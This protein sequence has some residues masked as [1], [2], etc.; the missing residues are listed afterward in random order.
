MGQ[1][2]PRQHK[3][4]KALQIKKREEVVESYTNTSPTYHSASNPASTLVSSS[5]NRGTEKEAEKTTTQKDIEEPQVCIYCKD[6]SQL[7]QGVMR[8][9][10]ISGFR[11][12]KGFKF[13]CVI[14]LPTV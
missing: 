4:G 3:E 8:D 2:R 6:H 10:V 5:G 9:S 14:M 1:K 13:F 12:V 11:S 7:I